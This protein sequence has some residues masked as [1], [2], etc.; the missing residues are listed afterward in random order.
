M[1]AE[2]LLLLVV[3]AVLVTTY[4]VL[5]RWRAQARRMESIIEAI[6]QG[7]LPESS[8]MHGSPWFYRQGRR[9]ERITA[10]QRELENELSE[11]AFNLKAV[12]GSMVEGVMV[13]DRNNRISL[14]NAEF[15]EL[16]NLDASPLGRTALESLQEANI[17]LLL[18]RVM[19]SGQAASSEV[20]LRITGRDDRQMQINAVP[21]FDEAGAVNGLVAV[22]HDI[23]RI[24]KL[25]RVR[26]EFVSAVSHELRTPL[27]I[28]RGYLETL[29]DAPTMTPEEIKRVL[30][31]MTRHSNRLNALVEDLF[32]LSRLESGQMEI[33][34]VTL[35]VDALLKLILEDYG[36]RL[37]EKEAVVELDLEP[38]LPPVEADR[39]KLEQVLFNL[40]DNA[41]A[42]SQPPRVVRISARADG[43]CLT[44]KVRDNGF[45]IPAGDLPHI[46]ERFYRV[47]KGRSRESGGTG[48]G[49]SIVKHIVEL[50][51]GT[52]DASSKLDE[53]TEICLCLPVPQDEDWREAADTP[54]Q[55]LKPKEDLVEAATSSPEPRT[56]SKPTP[57]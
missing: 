9:L 47:D 32:T 29:C 25:E 19:S 10:R 31:T 51:G 13:L 23:S 12:L 11:T 3:A 48:L 43:N 1:G 7:E 15:L 40:L 39:L 42:Y 4:V 45:G 6:A 56:A 33:Q 8:L 16:F 2:T 35:R 38:D 44:I 14:V 52:V 49:L 36:H 54:A 57:A 41:L 27:S 5:R 20:A 53:W 28:F 46:F 50:H 18:R 30:A 24:K 34:P 21:V 17:A 26:Q 37:E 55:A 22:F